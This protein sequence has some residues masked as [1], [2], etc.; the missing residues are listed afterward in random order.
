MKEVQIN[1]LQ[2]NNALI[3]G[4]SKQNTKTKTNKKNYDMKRLVDTFGSLQTKFMV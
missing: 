2:A 4:D 3:T 1:Y